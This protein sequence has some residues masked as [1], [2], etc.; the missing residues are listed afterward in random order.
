MKYKFGEPIDSK[1]MPKSK[2][3]LRQYDEC[4]R[5]FLASGCSNWKVNIEALPSTN[6]RVIL[7][8][9]KWRLNNV[10]EF[11]GKGINA[12]LN[13]SQVY[14]EIVKNNEDSI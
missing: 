3:R 7:S 6:A 5:E 13:K 9:L 1:E 2:R 14:L 11:K 8:S 10:D 12:F 4:L